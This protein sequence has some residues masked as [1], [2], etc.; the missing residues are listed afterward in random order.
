VSETKGVS[1][2]VRRRVGHGL[3]RWAKRYRLAPIVL[4][5]HGDGPPWR[6]PGIEKEAQRHTQCP[7]PSYDIVLINGPV[8][9]MNKYQAGLFI[10]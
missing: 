8:S 10:E 7:F 3:G 2:M 4:L 9:I 6:L 5:D 1:D